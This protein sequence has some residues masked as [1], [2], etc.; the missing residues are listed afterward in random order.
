MKTVKK[1]DARPKIVGTWKFLDDYSHENIIYGYLYYAKFH[2][3]K[4]KKITFPA[5]FN[6]P[7]FTIVRASD[8]PGKNIVPEPEPDQPFMA[9][10]EIFH[11]GQIIMGIAHPSKDILH[12]FVKNISIEFEKFPAITNPKLCLDNEKNAFGHEIVI[13]HR[14]NQK[15]DKDW[16]KTH[17]VYYTPHQEQ[18]YLEPQ[19]M[20]A[21]FDKNDSSMFVRGT[22]QCPFFV[23][24]AVE[25]IM[26]KEVSRVIVET[27]EGIGGGFGGKEDFPNIIAGI[28]ALLSYKSGRPVKTVMERADDIKIT[29]KRHPSRVEIETYTDSKTKK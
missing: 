3:G 22:M 27:S 1:F 9:E 23:K 13:D 28:T 19:G 16:V 10:N 21:I 12:D 20:M 17:S 8:I 15:T 7:E 18:L 26:G 29:T 4:I 25:T 24:E 14:K 11:F 5:D 6:L 2:R